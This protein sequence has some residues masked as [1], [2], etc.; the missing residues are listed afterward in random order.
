MKRYVFT[1]MLIFFLAGILYSADIPGLQ[2]ADVYPNFTNKGFKLTK[3]FGKIQ[4]EWRCVF[5]DS[6]KLFEV[7]VFSKNASTV[8][9]IEAT[10]IN[11]TSYNTN[12][13]AKEFLSYVATMPYT[14]SSPADAK[15][16]VIKNLGSNISKYFGKVK[17]ELFANTSK[18]RILR[19]AV[20]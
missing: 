3:N 1:F 13:I 16:W 19:M 2:P 12:E 10:V 8:K 7:V 9:V 15:N 5:E 6:S 11:Y 17:I 20:E 18:A 4:N 14:G